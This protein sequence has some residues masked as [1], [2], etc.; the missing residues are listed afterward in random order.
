MQEMNT[1]QQTFITL[2]ADGLSFDKIAEQLKTSKPTLIQWSKLFDDEIKDLQ[3]Q[4]FIKIK[5]AYSW[6]TKKRYETLLKQLN[7]I[8]ETILNVDYSQT[9]LKDLVT[10]KNNILSQID[11]IERNIKTNPRVTTTNELGYKEHL[12]FKLNE[13]T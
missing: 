10:I 13:L 9:P 7:K 8:D 12:D 1:K 6:N 4:A 11:T 5:E 3:F 2:R